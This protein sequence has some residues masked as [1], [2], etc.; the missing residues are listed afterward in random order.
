MLV[1]DGC[2]MVCLCCLWCV[3][4]CGVSIGGG[5]CM[6]WCDGVCMMVWLLLL[7]VVLCC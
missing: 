6:M 4:V 3:V 7:F 2:V 1:C 5:V